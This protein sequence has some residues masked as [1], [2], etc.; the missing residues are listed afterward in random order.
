MGVESRVFDRRVQSI[1]RTAE[2]SGFQ[3]RQSVMREELWLDKVK[4]VAG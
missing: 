1:Q 3:M 4:K 2:Q